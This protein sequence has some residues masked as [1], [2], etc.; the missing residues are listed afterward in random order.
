MTANWPSFD[1]LTPGERYSFTTRY[2]YT[3]TGRLEKIDEG[4]LL[5]IHLDNGRESY[6]NPRAIATVI[7]LVAEPTAAPH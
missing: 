2:G 6:V 7:E 5:C 1:S 3:F 4:G